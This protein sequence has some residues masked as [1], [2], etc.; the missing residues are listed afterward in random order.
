MALLNRKLV[1]SGI[2]LLAIAGNV[3]ADAVY[4]N[5]QLA[6]FRP[7]GATAG[8]TAVAAVGIPVPERRGMFL[9]AELATTLVDAKR[10]GQKMNYTGLGGYG[11]YQRMIDERFAVHLKAGLLYQYSER[12]E[13]DPENG[14]G[15]VF[16]LGGTIHQSREL[17][18]L[19]E[20]S[21]VQGTLDLT[22]LSLGIR[23]RF[24]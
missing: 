15:I 3:F 23:Y 13:N 4:I 2:L 18:Y 7:S 17:S 22:A 8:Y 24:R 1:T 14:A 9:E 10:N 21:S 20:L 6:L 11:V 5:G 16:A 19:I 12:E